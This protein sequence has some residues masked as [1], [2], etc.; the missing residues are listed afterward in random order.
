V[1]AARAGPAGAGAAGGKLRR[2]L[3]LRIFQYNITFGLYMLE[4]WERLVFNAAG[5]L[6]LGLVGFS[7]SKQ[8]GSIVQYFSGGQ[9]S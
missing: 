7:V 1:K 2:W 5:L 4:P 8:A 9:V 3:D 6:A